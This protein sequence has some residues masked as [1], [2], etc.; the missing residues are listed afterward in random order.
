MWQWAPQSPFTAA[1]TDAMFSCDGQFVYT[2]F[3][4][5][6]VGVFDGKSLWPCCRLAQ[7]FYTC[8]GLSGYVEHTSFCFPR[9]V[10]CIGS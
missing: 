4:D 2:S 10:I 7:P 1:I 8:W 9:R 6:C 3:A 5:G